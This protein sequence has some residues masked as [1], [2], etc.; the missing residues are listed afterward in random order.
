[1]SVG[2]KIKE[3]RLER[4]YTQEDIAEKLNV[5]RSYL[6]NIERGVK[7]PNVS[8]AGE[9]ADILKVTVDSLLGK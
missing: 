2:A 3:F 5:S 4:G 1:M 9:I 8:L 7:V 6:A